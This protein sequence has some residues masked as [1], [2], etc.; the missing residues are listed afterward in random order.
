MK[1]FLLALRAQVIPAALIPFLYDIRPPVSFVDG[2]LVV[3]IQDFRKTPEVRSRVVMRPAPETLPLTIDIML[4]RRAETWDEAMTL[5][6]ESRVMVSDVGKVE[7]MPRCRSPGPLRWSSPQPAASHVA[8]ADHRLP[9]R[10]P[11]TSAHL[12]SR[13]A[14]PHSPLP[15]PRRPIRTLRL[16]AHLDPPKRRARKK[17]ARWRRCA[18]SSLPGPADARSRRTGRCCD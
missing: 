2:C 5:E 4:G 3:E 11:S 10:L 15:S 6:L 18:S 8:L 16:T 14:T 1:P 17:T 12:H 13:R 7:V 9:P